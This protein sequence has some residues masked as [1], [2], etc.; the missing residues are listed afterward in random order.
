MRHLIG[1]VVGPLAIAFAFATA[2]NAEVRIGLAVPLTGPIAW[3]GAL[4]KQGFDLA[5]ADLNEVDG[6]LAQS[7]E[8]V[9][10]DDYCDPEQAV[11]AAAKLIEAEVR[12]VFGHECSGAAIAASKMY[13]EAGILLMSNFA[14]NPMLTEQGL[15]NVFRVI[16]RDDQQGKIAADLLAD[17]FPDAPIAIVHD[18]GAYGMGLAEEVRVSLRDRGIEETLFET[19]EPGGLDYSGILEK[20]RAADVQVL[21]YGGYIQEVGLLARQAH[22]RGYDLQLIAGDGVGTEDFALIAGAA[23][24]GTLFT[25]PPNPRSNPEAVPLASRLARQPGE[26]GTFTAYAALQAWAQ[27]VDKAGTFE[28]EAVAEALRS[29]EF[30]TVLGRIG[31][32]AKGDVTGYNTFVWY[33]WHDGDYAPVDPT[34]LTD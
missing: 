29:H 17:L 31:F 25:Y 33:R 21:Y 11:A 18:A 23:A 27:A 9:V 20:M 3:G 2:A 13:A 26:E 19:I 14:T 5:V 28:T 1:K 22:E 6:V 34:E 24:E 16:G 15:S 10:A 30:D 8:T 32:N 7:I 4:T 12:A